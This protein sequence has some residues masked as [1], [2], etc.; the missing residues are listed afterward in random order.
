MKWKHILR[1]KENFV[2]GYF[3]END[4]ISDDKIPMKRNG[5][6]KKNYI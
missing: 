3:L 1:E 6:E 5:R 2:T 4:N